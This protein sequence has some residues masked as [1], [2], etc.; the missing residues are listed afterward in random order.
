MYH[1][2]LVHLLKICHIV[3]LQHQIHDTAGR[4]RTLK[5]AAAVH[6]VAECYHKDENRHQQQ[7]L[8]G[9][10]YAEVDAPRQPAQ[11]QHK[12]IDPLF[13]AAFFYGGDCGCAALD[14]DRRC[15]DL[16]MDYTALSQYCW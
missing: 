5:Q 16:A 10:F 9:G 15:G 4:Q 2:T 11:K 1:L 14:L 8:E 3:A 12:R 13:P 6:I 7:K